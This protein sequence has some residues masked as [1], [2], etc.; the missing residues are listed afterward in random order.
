[1]TWG[2]V[3][4]AIWNSPTGRARNRCCAARRRRARCASRTAARP[5]RCMPISITPTS[6]RR[7][8]SS[9]SAGRRWPCAMPLALRLIAVP[10]PPEK[11][12]DARLRLKRTANK[13]QDRFDPRSL[14]AAGFMVLATTLPQDVPAAEIVAVYRLRWQIELAFKRLKSLLHIDRLPTRTKGGSLS[15]LYAHLI[16]LLVS[17]DICRDVLESSP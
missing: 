14:T 15:W 1:M 7:T 9:G 12:A 5:R 17:E 13:H 16:V 6:E 10:L 8:S 4:S 3:V 2:A 11:A